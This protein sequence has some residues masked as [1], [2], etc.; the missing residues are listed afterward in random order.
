MIISQSPSVL[1]LPPWHPRRFFSF[2]EILLVV[3]H[4]KE[5]DD[6]SLSPSVA[7]CPVLYWTGQF[8]ITSSMKYQIQ[9]FLR[10]ICGQFKL[11]F[12]SMFIY[13]HMNTYAQHLY[14]PP[15]QNKI[16]YVFGD[17]VSQTHVMTYSK[18]SSC[19]LWV[20]CVHTWSIISFLLPLSTCPV[21]CV[22]LTMT[23]HTVEEDASSCIQDG[24]RYSDKDVW[25]PEPC[26]ICVCDTGIVLCDEI[27]CE[28]LK[29]CP[30]P[31]I[32]FGECCPICAAD[33]SPPIGRNLFISHL[34]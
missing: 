8:I 30:K 12:S 2:E 3:I 6:H 14:L 1:P 11:K 25:K 19:C 23:S 16:L 28:E 20:T 33:P 10:R 32:P 15:K 5:V 13:E 18:Y 22:S 17:F 34:S 24:Q 21:P 4:Y 9:L 29:D 31:E 27:V 7:I 26:R